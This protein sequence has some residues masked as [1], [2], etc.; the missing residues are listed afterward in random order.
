M[1]LGSFN[2]WMSMLGTQHFGLTFFFTFS[3]SQRLDFP[4]ASDCLGRRSCLCFLSRILSGRPMWTCTTKQTFQPQDQVGRAESC[5][6]DRRGG[7]CW[8]GSL[9]PLLANEE[10]ALL[11]SSGYSLLTSCWFHFS[12]VFSDGSHGQHNKDCSD[13]LGPVVVSRKQK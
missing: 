5:W 10:L 1:L 11:V 2:R 7:Y 9:L 6:H 12:T 8:E 4:G 13:N 3:C